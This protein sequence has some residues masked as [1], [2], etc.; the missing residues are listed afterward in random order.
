MQAQPWWRPPFPLQ[1]LLST[2]QQQRPLLHQQQHQEQLQQQ[3]QPRHQQLRR[4]PS[5]SQ[6]QQQQGAGTVRS[7][8]AAAAAASPVLEGS[9]AG[10]GEWNL[11]GTPNF[12]P[13]TDPGT[14][15]EHAP[16]PQ[17]M[18]VP[19]TALAPSLLPPAQPLDAH[20]HV[21]PLR[22]PSALFLPP[23]HQPIQPQLTASQ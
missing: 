7:T 19:I 11:L 3:H 1:H 14:T 6:Q 17:H 2:P 12:T 5:V 21:L 15:V 13:N 23:T 18:P 9:Q 10:D 20:A 4:Q 16:T 8:A 22:T